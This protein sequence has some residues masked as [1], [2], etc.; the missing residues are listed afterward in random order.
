MKI[1][2]LDDKLID[3]KPKTKVSGRNGSLLHQRAGKL[4]NAIYPTLHILEEVPV[5]IRDKQT[6]YLDYYIPVLNTAVEIQGE[7]HFKYTP[8]FHKSIM[9]F[10]KARQRDADKSL[11]CENNG[12]ILIQLPFNEDDNDWTTRIKG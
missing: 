10:A 9:G 1:R 7:Q 12:I 8:H 11:W 4:L 6:L 3:W 2:D 5:P